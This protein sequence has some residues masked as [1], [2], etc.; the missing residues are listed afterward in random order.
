MTRETVEIKIDENFKKE[1]LSLIDNTIDKVMSSSSI[2]L[3]KPEKTKLR[4]LTLDQLNVNVTNKMN[5]KTLWIFNTENTIP[6]LVEKESLHP[7]MGTIVKKKK[8][9]GFYSI[10]PNLSWVF[11]KKNEDGFGMTRSEFEKKATEMFLE[12]IETA[13]FYGSL[14]YVGVLNGR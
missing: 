4:N 13:A 3:S 12:D 14:S 10:K 7:D 1:V 9:S 11:T 5:F 6:V 8:T 2:K